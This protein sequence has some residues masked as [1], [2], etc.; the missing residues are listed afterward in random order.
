[1]GV[2]ASERCTPGAV[3]HRFWR[4]AASDRNRASTGWRWRGTA[5]G[6]GA[7]SSGC[8]GW[9]WLPPPP[10]TWLLCAAPSARSANATSGPTCRVRGGS[11]CGRAGSRQFAGA[12]NICRPAGRRRRWGSESLWCKPEERVWR[13]PGGGKPLTEGRPVACGRPPLCGLVTPG[14][15]PAVA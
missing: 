3:V 8:S 2:A 14:E 11:R 1:M 4:W 7:R 6:P 10:G 5:T 12:R 15:K 13:G 9:P